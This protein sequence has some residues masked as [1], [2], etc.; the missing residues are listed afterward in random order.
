LGSVKAVKKRGLPLNARVRNGSD[1]HERKLLEIASRKTL[2][3][4][5]GLIEF[6]R[7]LVASSEIP[8]SVK[9][10]AHR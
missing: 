3:I 1:R 7:T 8:Q 6:Q 10:C 4:A 9:L 5:K 2:R